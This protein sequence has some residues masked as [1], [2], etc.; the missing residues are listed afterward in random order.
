MAAV[1]RAAGLG[2]IGVTME[3]EDESRGKTE[4]SGEDRGDGPPD[5]DPTLS[6]SAFI[7]RAIQQ[8]MGSSLQADLP[9]DKDGSRCHGLQWRRCR[10]PRSEP[11]PQESGGADTATVLDMAADSFLAGLVSVLDPPDTWVP[12]RLDLRPGETEDMLE[13][14]AEVRIGD[15]DPIPLPVPSLLPRLRAWRT[16]KTGPQ[17][18]TARTLDSSSEK[19]RRRSGAASSSSSREKG[20]RRKAPDGGD[21]DRDRDRSSKKAR[22]PKESAPPSGPP[23]KP[24]VSSGSGSS[25]SS[26]SC[27]SRK[28]KLQSKVAVLIREG[29]SS[30]TPAKDSASAG[31]GSIG[32]KFSRD[33]ESRSP[34]LKPDERAPAE[35]A[36]ATPGST[37]P[38][39]T[40]VKAKAGA[41]KAKG[42]KGKT[43]PSKTRKKIR[44]GGSSGASGGP[45][46]LKKSKADS[47]S[48]AAGAKGAEETS[49]SGEERA[50][51]APSTPP[52]KAAPPPP[53]LTPDSQTVD[54]SCKTPEVSFLPEEAAEE[55]G[56]RG[57]AEEEE[58]EEEEEEEEQQQPATTTA[59]STAPAAPSAAPSAGS[60]AGDSGAED[61][62][63]TRAS[64]LPTLPP[65]M[66]WN[67]PT[68]VDCTTSG[69]LA[70]TALLFKMEEANLAS[71]A[72]AQELIQATNQILSHRKPPSA[73]G[74]T[75]A[76]VPTSLGLPPGPSSYL[77]P[78][79]LPLG[80]CGSTPPTPT[81]LAAAS[82]KREGSSS[83][84]GRG[85]TDKYL[86]KLHT[87][88]RAVEEVKLAIKPYYQKKD[89]TKEEYK[90]I[91]RKAVHKICHSKS[92]EI[93]PVKVSNLVRAYVQRLPLLPQARPQ[94]R[95]PP[96]TTPA[97]QGAWAPG[98]GLPLPPL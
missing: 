36:K 35:A 26:S 24:P 96:R 85:D 61:G 81:G 74:V 63:A 77:L 72:K 70:L 16:G 94:A 1:V 90:D 88:E 32:V 75:P 40:K 28:V 64:Q 73:L 42:T 45:V 38:K 58:D 9:N 62:P 37:K 83:S 79:S 41:K 53:A 84:E 6:S 23:P 44:S 51:K 18:L 30:T 5:R 82:D 3:E 80:G 52:P 93:N 56:I 55:A 71:R 21:R 48:Q 29:V 15:R 54:S 17:Q 14:V 20:S 89:I 49:W 11:C 92:G 67:L 91:L 65:P 60:T 19:D 34:F 78:G 33:R 95:G 31:L 69:V 50:A 27:S 68:G 2:P 10:S 66:P 7:L 13:L 59:T 87:Q 4:E 98:R 43:K 47:C 46:S 8:A 57:G 76:P 25:S 97:T 22:P 86:K 39:K 12:S